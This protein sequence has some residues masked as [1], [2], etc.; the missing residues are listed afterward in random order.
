[1]SATTSIRY[2]ENRD[3]CGSFPKK[4]GVSD[5]FLDYEDLI[6]TSEELSLGSGQ[7]VFRISRN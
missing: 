6:I 1:M 3:R 2:K 7:I 4:I 5:V